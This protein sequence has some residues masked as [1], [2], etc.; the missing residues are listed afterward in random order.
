M[1]LPYSEEDLKKYLGNVKGLITSYLGDPNGQLSGI[2]YEDKIEA[3][4]Y[5]VKEGHASLP[6]L[7]ES[8]PQLF[9]AKL[10]EPDKEH[11]LEFM[12]SCLRGVLKNK[13]RKH[14]GKIRK[15]LEREV[16]STI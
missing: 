12:T 9:R 11:L 5:I 6:A 10:S 3:M 1:A 2:H 7:R 8:F 14:Q 13:Q 16:L 4:V 15:D